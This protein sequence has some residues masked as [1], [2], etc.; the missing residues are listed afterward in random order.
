MSARNHKCLL[1]GE[2]YHV[3][4]SCDVPSWMWTYCCEQCWA[5]SQKGLMCLA[6]GDRL[7]RILEPHE[8]S[9]LKQGIEEES[10]F[11]D[12]ILEGMQLPRE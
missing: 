5:A 2:S 9:I 11:L 6:L 7:A 3:C 8:L 12:K 4:S 1:C 10:H